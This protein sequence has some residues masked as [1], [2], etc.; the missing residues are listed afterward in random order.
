MGDDITTFMG[1]LYAN[2]ESLNQLEPSGPIQACT[3]IALIPT[4]PFLLVMR[5]FSQGLQGYIITIS[6]STMFTTVSI[7]ITEA[8]FMKTLT[9]QSNCHCN[10]LQL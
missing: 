4:L 7:T 3:G 5:L 9:T 1:R 10:F 8:E 2:S 6:R